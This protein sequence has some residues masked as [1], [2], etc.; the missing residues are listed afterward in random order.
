MTLFLFHKKAFCFA[1]AFTEKMLRRKPV[2]KE[3]QISSFGKA[4]LSKKRFL[5]KICAILWL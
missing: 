1:K 5:V 2:L 3:K 4:F